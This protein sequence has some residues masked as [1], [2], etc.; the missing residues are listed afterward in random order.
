MEIAG[1]VVLDACVLAEAAVSD[2]ILRLSEKP[3]LISPK[4]TEEI[5]LEV[6][7]TW[8]D[9]LD[10]PPQIAESR[11]VAATGYFPEA[12]VSDYEIH[13]DEC[14]NDLKDRHVLAAAIQSG[15]KAIITFN[16]NDFPPDAL[17]PWTVSAVHP[18][19]LL[20]Q[21]FDQDSSTVL[22]AVEAMAAKAGRGTPEM[23]SRLAWHVKQFS[24]HVGSSMSIAV[25]E[26]PPRN[27]RRI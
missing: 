19:E 5:W 1:P 18:N 7:R 24:L 2:L 21:L 11:V 20:I 4:W 15:S 9:K 23:L 17:D 14:K 6:Q 22:S 26:I 25:P 10:W 8:I 16:I 27:W 12:M 3:R 13:I